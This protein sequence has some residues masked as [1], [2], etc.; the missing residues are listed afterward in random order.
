MNKSYTKFIAAAKEL[1]PNFDQNNY[2]ARK[3]F[4]G[5]WDGGND[6]ANIV[7]IN[8]TVGHLST[9]LDAANG[10]WNDKLKVANQFVNWAK[11]NLG[12]PTITDFETAKHAVGSE[13][14]KAFKGGQAS[15][16]EEEIKSWTAI[17]SNANSEEQLQAA[18][19][20]SA[21]LLSSR[22]KSLQNNYKRVMGDYPSESTLFPETIHTLERVG[23]DPN[24]FSGRAWENS[25]TGQ[26]SSA[27][28]N[29]N[30]YG[31]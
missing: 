22:M 11:D 15:P 20:Q 6:S 14:A 3:K 2:S 9:L 13:L 1:N 10:L 24:E 23:F 7:S 30:P 27:P 26:N 18:I 17:F 28:D 29:N 19:K 25:G 4:L 31:I 5:S 16:T 12:D 8:T 21:K